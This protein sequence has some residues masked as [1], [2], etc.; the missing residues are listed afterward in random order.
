MSLFAFALVLA[1][2]LLNATWNAMVKSVDDRLTTLALLTLGASILVLPAVLALP[3]PAPASWPYLALSVVINHVYFAALLMS[4]RFGDLGF[5]YTIGRGSSPLVIALFAWLAAGETLSPAGLA[6]VTLLSG[7]ILSLAL[8]GR[9]EPRAVLWALLVGVSIAGFTVS[10]GIGSRLSGS[11]LGYTCWMFLL[12]GP[13]LT[14]F[15]LWRRGRGFLAA[16]GRTWRRAAAGSALFVVNY[17]IVIWVM[18]FQPIA[19]VAAVRE[20]SVLF[21]ALIGARLLGEPFGGR[22]LAAAAGVCAG[23][24]LLQLS[25]LH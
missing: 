17:A 10:D 8:G 7:A 1:A 13:P 12:N 4:Y 6:A 5:V 22:R 9:G 21:A 25:R 18:G 11:S 23:A 19:A 2:A 24:A 3:A 14:L 16:A 15:A 20:T